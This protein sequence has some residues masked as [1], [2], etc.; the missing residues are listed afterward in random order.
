[1]PGGKKPGPSIKHPKQYE[2]IKDSLKEE[3]PKWSEERIKSSAA[4]ISNSK[5]MNQ[6]IRRKR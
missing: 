6:F 4:A 3:H 1:M 2:A 5:R